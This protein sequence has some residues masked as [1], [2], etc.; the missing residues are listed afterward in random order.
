MRRILK[1]G[2]IA[3]KILAPIATVALS[4]IVA[5]RLIE[6][7]PP[8]PKQEETEVLPAVYVARAQRGPV[9]FPVRSQGT[10]IPRTESTLIAQVA[11]RILSVADS[12]DESRFFRRSDIL[13]QIDP[14]D[15]DVRIRRLEASIQAAKAQKAEAEQQLD[16]QLKLREREATPQ[17][18]LDQAQAAFDVANAHLAELD[19]QLDEAQNAKEDTAVVAPF[20]GCIREKNVDVGQYVTPGT[21]LATCFAT[22]AVEVRL[23]ID[24]HEFAFLDLALGSSFAPGEGPE[25]ILEADFG[26]QQLRWR[27]NIVRS[28]AIV[29]RKSRMAYLVASV[30]YPYD[31]TQQSNG[32]PLAVGMFVE[33][34]IRSCEVQDAI[35]LPQVCLE[36]GGRVFTIDS[37][38]RLDEK[39]VRVIRREG[40]WAVVRGDLTNDQR[41]CATHLERAVDGTRVEVVKDITREIP[42]GKDGRVLDLC[43]DL[44]G[45]STDPRVA[46]AE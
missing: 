12:F 15:Y 25:A 35:V 26:G 39:T 5:Q 28:E 43:G 7:K 33:T 14:R 6:T 2:M 32:H 4:V 20:D 46:E 1:I 17:S 19:A 45:W 16:R 8:P 30:A 21:P 40:E 29:D 37:S 3:L 22:D 38:D 27:G 24:D 31:A 36:S 18:V 34:A 41:V 10:V 23:P 44:D 11:G 13:V 42:R 9:C